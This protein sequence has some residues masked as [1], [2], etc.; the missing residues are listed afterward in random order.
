MKI[1]M[2]GLDA[3]A[4]ISAAEILDRHVEEVEGILKHDELKPRE[5]LAARTSATEAQLLALELRGSAD[6]D[7]SAAQDQ[8]RSLMRQVDT[9][10]I[11]NERLRRKHGE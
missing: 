3:A 5:A 7:L 10:K 1:N 9:L 6:S 2:S 8:V 11:E 4:R